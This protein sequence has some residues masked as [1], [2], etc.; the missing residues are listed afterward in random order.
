MLM[1]RRYGSVS[2]RV[3]NLIKNQKLLQTGALIN[4]TWTENDTFPVY[5]PG[6][7]PHA[8][9]KIADV[10]NGSMADYAAAIEAASTAFALYKRTTGRFRAGL[11]ANMHR[12]MMDNQADLARLIA[13]ENG[14]PYADAYGEVAYAA[15]F[16]QWFGE[17]A[18]HVT[19]DIIPS[20][21]P[22]NKILAFRQPVGVCGIITPWNFPAAMITRKL[23]AA[24]SVGCTTVVKPASETPLTALAMAQLSIDAGFPSGVVNVIPCHSAAEAGRAIC[25]HPQVKKVSFTGSTNVG[26]IL[27]KQA[28][29]TLKK[30]LFE[31]GGNAPFIVFDDVDVDA[32]VAGVVGAKFRS[33]GQT[34]V[35]ANRIFVHDTVYD[36]FAHKLVEKL[37][38]TVLGYS[39]DEGTT[40]GPLIH[41]RS[42]NKVKDHIA[43]A[44]RLGAS[45]L[46]GGHPQPHLGDYYHDLTVLGDVTPEM[47]IFH[48]ETFGPVC[49]LIRFSSD[50][51][52][53]RLANDSD[54]G[55]A[56]Y[57][58]TKDVSR[59]FRVAE[60]LDVGMMGVNTGAIL[61][62]AL[63][64]GGVKESGFG[65]EG[66][67][68]GVEDYTVV[69]SMVLGNVEPTN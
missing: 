5:D 27:M 51:E 23:A 2:A 68:F 40:H 66:S 15:L 4:G 65:R 67:K 31:L 47:Q 8:D 6:R 50:D 18:A 56:G 49:P 37:R 41:E 53:V 16:F 61:E 62:A 30:C 21:T 7:V 55:L 54:V 48:E 12:L 57:F 59:V 52:V 60:E 19:G 22:G 33:S 64:F 43:D 11:L 32:A 46:L 26:K 9:A 10:T 24:T 58:Y 13:L 42:L 29:L 17:E 14:K 34:C 44:T 3:S 35:C 63:P 1:A 39:L 25:E 20:A 45:V 69:K 38:S 36:E 28:A